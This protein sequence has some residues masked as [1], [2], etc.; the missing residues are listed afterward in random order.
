MGRH[1]PHVKRV[2]PQSQPYGRLAIA[3]GEKK[4]EIYI[5]DEIPIHSDTAP[6][7]QPV[8]S[9]LRSSIPSGGP[10]A[11]PAPSCPRKTHS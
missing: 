6:S 4:L 9:D 7:S 2:G 10:D 11:A 5:F 3:G 8:Y 1:G